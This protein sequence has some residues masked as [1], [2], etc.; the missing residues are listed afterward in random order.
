MFVLQYLRKLNIQKLYIFLLFLQFLV[1]CLAAFAAARP[2]LSLERRF[3]IPQLGEE[4]EPEPL[5]PQPR[6]QPRPQPQPFVPAQPPVSD[7]SFLPEEDT[8]ELG[9][10]DLPSSVQPIESAPE[11][12]QPVF[13]PA[14]Q[15]FVQP[16]QGS[17]VQASPARSH[18]DQDP[19]FAHIVSEDRLEP[20]ADG[21]A[22]VRYETSHGLKRVERTQPDADG[23][24]TVKGSYR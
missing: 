10:S 2:Q 21:H 20:T 1:L 18:L 12:L 5:I 13:L 24:N 7:V 15:E 19:R 4:L 17:A 11:P 16:L 22:G 23:F 9:S 14:Q 8:F 3:P 6:P